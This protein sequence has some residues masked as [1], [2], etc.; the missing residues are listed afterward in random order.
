MESQKQTREPDTRWAEHMMR[1]ADAF[2]RE[3]RGVV[4][5]GFSSHA[6][7]SLREALLAIRSLIDSGIERLEEEE[8][9]PAGKP[10][11][12]EVE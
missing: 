8:R 3:M 7:G 1:A 9:K 4:P 12:V 5:D 2:A 6:R 10:R 11:K